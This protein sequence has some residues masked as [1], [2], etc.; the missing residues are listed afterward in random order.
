MCINTGNFRD[1]N[2][3]LQASVMNAEQEG[4]DCTLP[5]LC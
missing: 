4:L 5:L 1:S 2:L 3:D